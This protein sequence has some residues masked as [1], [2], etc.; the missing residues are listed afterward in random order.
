[1]I[2]N[3]ATIMT[4]SWRSCAIFRYFSTSVCSSELLPDSY[5][6]VSRASQETI[7]QDRL[8]F[9]KEREKH[10]ARMEAQREEIKMLQDNIEQQKVM[11]II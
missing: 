9:E 8:T 6:L 2:G 3:M 11:I 1:M 10:M 5:V 7:Q 4:N